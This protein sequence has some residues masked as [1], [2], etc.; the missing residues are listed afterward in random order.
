VPPTGAPWSRRAAGAVIEQ[1]L[2]LLPR[3]PARATFAQLHSHVTTE[4]AG[5]LPRPTISAVFGQRRTLCRAA[6]VTPSWLCPCDRCPPPAAERPENSPPIPWL[7]L[8]P[9][10]TRGGAGDGRRLM[11]LVGIT[12]A[13]L[14]PQPSKPWPASGS[15]PPLPSRPSAALHLPHYGRCWSCSSLL[16]VQTLPHHIVFRRCERSAGR[17]ARSSTHSHRRVIGFQRPT[18]YVVRDG[19]PDDSTQ[20]ELRCSMMRRFN[21]CSIER[22]RRPPIA[23]LRQLDWRSAICWSGTTSLPAA[24]WGCSSAMTTP[25]RRLAYDAAPRRAKSSTWRSIRP[26]SAG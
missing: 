10:A 12:H 23:A 2:R 17:S 22:D 4:G 20:P 5:V 21:P 3:G 19:K 11:E 6:D 9:P 13:A 18:T 15:T 7:P 1:P 14:T 16:R 24:A 8:P 25:E 26:R